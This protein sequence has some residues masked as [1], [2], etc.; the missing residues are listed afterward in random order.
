MVLAFLHRKT[1]SIFDQEKQHRIGWEE[2][3]KAGSN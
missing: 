1:H 3:V 2:A